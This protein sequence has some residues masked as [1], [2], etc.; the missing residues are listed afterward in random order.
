MQHICDI[1]MH[2]SVQINM[3]RLRTEHSLLFYCTVVDYSEYL[4]AVQ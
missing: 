3:R 4:I 1:Y 2:T